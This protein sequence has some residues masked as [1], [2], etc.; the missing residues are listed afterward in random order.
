MLKVYIEGAE[1]ELLDKATESLHNIYATF[2]ELHDR[3]VPGCT[4]SY[5]NFSTNRL[6]LNFGTEK[7]LSIKK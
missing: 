6:Y 2:I 5:L 4:Q 3:F 7:Y 1:K